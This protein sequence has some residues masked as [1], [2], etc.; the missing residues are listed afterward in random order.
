MTNTLYYGDELV[1]LAYLDPHP[2]VNQ[3]RQH[4]DPPEGRRAGLG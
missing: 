2:S 4:V 1:D 3:L